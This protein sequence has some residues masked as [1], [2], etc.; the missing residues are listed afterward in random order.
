MLAEWTG[1]ACK[2]M[3]LHG[4]TRKELSEALGWT[5]RYLTMVLNCHR[6]PAGAEKKIMGAIQAIIAE[7]NND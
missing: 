4:I 2:L 3:H 1:D 5:D 7:R 6:T